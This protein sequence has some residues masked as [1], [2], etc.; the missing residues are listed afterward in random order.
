MLEKIFVYMAISDN[1]LRMR[2][3]QNLFWA[4]SF[5]ESR[6]DHMSDL[7]G[8]YTYVLLYL[9]CTVNSLPLYA[10]RRNVYHLSI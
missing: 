1:L 6:N 7:N 3:N 9:I 2:N 4:P 8:T 10:S 5:K